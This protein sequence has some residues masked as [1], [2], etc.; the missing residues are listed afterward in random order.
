MVLIPWVTYICCNSLE[1]VLFSEEELIVEKYIHLNSML[2]TCFHEA[3]V[4]S[5]HQSTMQLCDANYT[6]R[7]TICFFLALIMTLLWFTKFTR[8]NGHSMARTLAKVANDM[9]VELCEVITR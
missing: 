8:A 2:Q 4:T 7:L 5:S 3:R 1:R 6:M 9:K